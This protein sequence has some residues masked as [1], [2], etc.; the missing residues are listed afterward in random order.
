MA[1]VGTTESITGGVFAITTVFLHLTIYGR[2]FFAIG[3]NERAAHYSGI[4]TNW[5]KILAY[6]LC[7]TFAAIYG[8][9]HV[10]HSISVVPSE[11]GSFLELYAIAGAVVL[12][13]G[14]VVSAR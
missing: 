3:S 14:R 4:N 1:Q 11:T 9:I 7:S 13:R 2:Y 8:L 5:Y 12:G 6:V 10:A